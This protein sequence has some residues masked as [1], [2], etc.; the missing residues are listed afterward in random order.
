MLNLMQETGHDAD[1]EDDLMCLSLGLDDDEDSLD[2]ID[3]ADNNLCPPFI[4]ETTCTVLIDVLWR[5][6]EES[7]AQTDFQALE[8]F[9]VFLDIL[10]MQEDISKDHQQDSGSP[11]CP[12]NRLSQSIK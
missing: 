9:R 4:S 8:A 6:V 3:E 2:D 5:S 10:M 1:L 11:L 7:E 12:Q